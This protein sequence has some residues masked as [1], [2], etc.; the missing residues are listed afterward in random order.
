MT[1]F[2]KRRS[3]NRPDIVGQL[4]R[5]VGGE[6][7]A[8]RDGMSWK[9]VRSDGYVVRSYAESVLEFDGYSDTNFLTVYYG[10]DGRWLGA[11]GVIHG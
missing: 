3:R 9:W 7:K 4:A 2:Q 10:S 11:G 5:V 6:W 8:V 1:L